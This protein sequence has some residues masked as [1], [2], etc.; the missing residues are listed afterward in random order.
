LGGD[1]LVETKKKYRPAFE[2]ILEES[3]GEIDQMK[4][5]VRQSKIEYREK[6]YNTTIS[7]QDE[8]NTCVFLKSRI[9]QEGFELGRFK[10]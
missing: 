7:L 5:R 3:K 6:V 2:V 1:S 10:I 4:I 9:D 8:E